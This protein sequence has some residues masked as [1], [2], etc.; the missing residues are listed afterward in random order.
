MNIKINLYKSFGRLESRAPILLAQ[1]CKDG[2][3]SPME[4]YI[5]FI[6]PYNLNDYVITLS[7]DAGMQI[8]FRHSGNVVLI[9]RDFIIT[10]TLNIGLTLYINGAVA[11]KWKIEPITFVEPDN[12]FQGLAEYE[13]LKKELVSVK[14]EM[15]LLKRSYSDSIKSLAQQVEKLLTN[16]AKEREALSQRIKTLEDDPLKI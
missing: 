15:V 12:G 6:T 13:L 11:K 10:S 1:E 3:I 4:M 9:P 7:N 16:A 5:E 2:T 14:K 8:A